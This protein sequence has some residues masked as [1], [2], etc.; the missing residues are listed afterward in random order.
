MAEVRC[1]TRSRNVQSAVLRSRST[2]SLKALA[3]ATGSFRHVRNAEMRRAA[4]GPPQTNQRF[5]KRRRNT[6]RP[7]GNNTVGITQLVRLASRMRCA[8]V[9]RG[10]WLTILNMNGQRRQLQGP[11]RGLPNAM[12]SAEHT[13]ELQSLMSISYDV[14]CLQKK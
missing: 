10:V 14:F 6:E 2:N 1:A 12:R 4:L 13:S 11:E 9:V 7:I 8:F 5:W 3:I